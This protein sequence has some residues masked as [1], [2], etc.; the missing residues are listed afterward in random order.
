MDV[1]CSRK[2][3]SEDE[4]F[5]WL[6]TFLTILNDFTDM[7]ERQHYSPSSKATMVSF[8]R[9]AEHV[10]NHFINHRVSYE[11]S[12]E[13]KNIHKITYGDLKI[14]R[15]KIADRISEI[16]ENDPKIY[17]RFKEFCDNLKEPRTLGCSL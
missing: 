3:L 9:V 7:A 14:E 15:D 4:Y 8:L 6:N 12:S 17:K 13:A 11:F 10:V 1:Q 2:K 16:I 5:K